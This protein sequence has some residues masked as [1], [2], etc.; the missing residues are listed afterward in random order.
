[1]GSADL[2]ITDVDVD[3]EFAVKV[4][5]ETETATDFDQS[6][7]IT[8]EDNANDTGVFRFSLDLGGGALTGGN[9]AEVLVTVGGDAAGGNGTAMDADFTQAVIAAII[10]D[11][12]GAGIGAA[13]NGDGTVT[14]T[15]G[16]SDPLFFDVDLTSVDDELTDSPE[17]LTLSLSAPTVTNGSA[18]VAAGMGSADLTITDTDVLPSLADQLFMNEVGI[19]VGDSPNGGTDLH[20]IEL[21]NI[22]NN[23]IISAELREVDIEIVGPSGEVVT[24]DLATFGGG[25]TFKI[26]GNALLVI[27]EDGTWTTYKPNGD[28]SK[29]GTWDTTGINWST[30][31]AGLDTSDEIGVNLIQEV[32][33]GSSTFASIDLLLANGV[34]SSLLTGVDGNVTTNGDDTAT[35]DANGDVWSGHAN[36]LP[37]DFDGS[38]LKSFVNNEQYN[39]RIGNQGAILA[40]IIELGAVNNSASLPVAD[41][42]TAVF[43]RVYD[44]VVGDPTKGSAVDQFAIDTEREDDWTTTDVPTEGSDNDASSPN[45]QDSRNDDFNPLQATGD[46][47]PRDPDDGQ[48]IITDADDGNSSDDNALSGGRGSD[49]IYGDDGNDTLNG[50][51]NNDFLFGGVGVDELN[52]GSGADLLVDLQGTDTLNGDTG[53]DTLITNSSVL[54][55]YSGAADTGDD[56]LNGGAGNDVIF[57]GTGADTITGGT[58][59]DW[60]FGGG[61]ADDFVFAPGDGGDGTGTFLDA[62]DVI[63]DFQDGA[64]MIDLSAFGLTNS[65]D[66]TIVNDAGGN[67][68]IEVTGVE[69]LVT[70]TGIDSSQLTDADFNF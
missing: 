31:W 7:T 57:A 17:T 34:N 44:G 65:G 9:E 59:N 50:E 38:L 55:G 5:D 22:F 42:E 49:F 64:D 47:T 23:A 53:D 37:A 54:D 19:G 69:F 46:V 13:D 20:Y 33:P 68:T 48:T 4:R 58:G 39:G 67:A 11:A 35:I 51:E 66:L 8:E 29:S 62:G 63:D 15:W 43:A 3:A 26:V 41:G 36:S 40:A 60:M 30:I 61:G 52:G 18:T 25:N 27:F 21:K 12:T 16:E 6:A 14:L 28:V 32:T 45:P 70:L 1:M 2:T 24:L 56:I 10:A